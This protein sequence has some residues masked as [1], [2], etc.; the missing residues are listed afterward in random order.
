MTTSDRYRAVGLT[1]NPFI[2]QQKQGKS[3]APIKKLFVARGA[4]DLP[5]PGSRTLL[6]VIG[7]AGFGKSTHLEWWRSLQPGP[8]HYVPRE[9]YKA[10][11]NQPPLVK[12]GFKEA[13]VYGDEVDRMPKLLRSR[14]FRHLSQ[15]R[16]TLVIGTHVDLADLGKRSGFDVITHLLEPLDLPTLID[17]V[18]NRLAAFSTGKNNDTLFT[19]SELE[20]VLRESGGN[21]REAEVLCHKLLAMKV[22]S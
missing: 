13:M 3:V 9:P 19:V 8:L 6:Q 20:E 18:E 15:R 7:D 17:I 10:R 14:W 12:A 11:W 21:P 22:G 2:A 4:P 16:A 1:G 5:P